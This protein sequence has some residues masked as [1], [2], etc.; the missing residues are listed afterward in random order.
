M[1]DELDIAD[2]IGNDNPDTAPEGASESEAAEF[3]AS[4]APGEETP[5]TETPP[6]VPAAPAP[7][8][9]ESPEFLEAVE[10]ES[11]RMVDLRI[12]QIM[13]EAQQAQ[14]QPQ[15]QE[16]ETADWD[17]WDPLEEGSGAKLGQLMQQTLAQ[18]AGQIQQSIQPVTQSFEQQ[19]EQAVLAEGAQRMDDIIADD[20]AKN[21]EIVP[22]DLG[23]GQKIDPKDLIRQIAPAFLPDGVQKYGDTPVGVQRAAEAALYRAAHTIRSLVSAAEKQGRTKA[24]NELGA[25]AGAPRDLSGGGSGALV[26]FPEGGDELDV[27]WRKYATT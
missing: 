5:A 19:A 14:Q 25:L 18:F 22:L 1:T 8:T 15:T 10:R 7:F 3:Q 20:Y 4:A 6:E 23:D 13:Q 9:H 11:A 12:E 27:D 17:S 21:G 24:E 26:T 16:P 2:T